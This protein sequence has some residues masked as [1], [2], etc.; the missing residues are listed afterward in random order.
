MIGAALPEGPI[1]RSN[2]YQL[3]AE[4]LMSEIVE[5]DLEEGS[6]VPTEKELSAS[7]GV[8]RSSVREGLR[9]LESQGV[10]ELSARGSYVVGSRRAAMARALRTLLALGEATLPEI[11][12]LRAPLE[13]AI[14][15]RAALQRTDA[16]IAAM[17]DAIADLRA[18]GG[19][20]RAAL[21]ADRAFHLALARASHNG[22]LIAAITG[23]REVLGAL[24]ASKL[25]DAE[26]AARQH[27]AILGRIEAGDATGAAAEASAHMDWI[28][29]TL[30]SEMEGDPR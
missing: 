15:G 2:V 30:R 8:G 10:I 29:G 4:R 17:R 7:Y 19:D 3:V 26:T 6:P 14:A 21:D 13:G 24:I 5:K 18:A 11:H 28:A 25:I 23:V 16:D 12:G 20:L 27:A 9:M 22:A 1:A